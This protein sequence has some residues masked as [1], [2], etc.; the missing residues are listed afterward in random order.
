MQLISAVLFDAKQNGA[1]T[2]AKIVS[3][4]FMQNILIQSRLTNSEFKNQCA[5]RGVAPLISFYY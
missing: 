1:I 3:S 2:H 4:F 5:E